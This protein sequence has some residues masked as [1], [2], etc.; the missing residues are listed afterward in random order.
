[1]KGIQPL[2]DRVLIRRLKEEEE[3]VGSI[4]IP[5]TARERPQQGE[6]IA[7]GPGRRGEEGKRLPMNLKAGDR[8]LFGKYAGSDVKVDDEE[9][10]VMHETEIYAVL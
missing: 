10:I 9:Y 3:R 1:M 4:I 7:V 5:D 2:G 6:V 8:V